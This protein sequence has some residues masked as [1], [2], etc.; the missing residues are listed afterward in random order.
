M[1]SAQAISVQRRNQQ[2]PSARLLHLQPDGIQLFP[3]SP[4]R[5]FQVIDKGGLFRH[6]RA[7]CPYQVHR[8]GNALGGYAVPA[9]LLF[10]LQ[11]FF[12]GEYLAV[13]AYCVSRFQRGTQ[14]S[15]DAGRFRQ[16]FFVEL[17]FRPFQLPGGLQ[18]VA[19]VGPQPGF[20]A[21]DDYGSCRPCESR[22]P[23]PR[24]P[25]G[26]DIF[27]QVGVCAGNDEGGYALFVESS[28]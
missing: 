13:Y 1:F 3:A 27:A 7:V 16:H 23:L 17:Y 8:V 15:W 28:P 18:E 24:F 12:H 14:E 4:A 21:G 9:K 25:V 5:I 26:G 2:R 11:R 10:Q 20:V 19:G 6:R 22:N